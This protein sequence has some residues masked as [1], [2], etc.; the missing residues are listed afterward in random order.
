MPKATKA[1]GSGSSGNNVLCDVED[2]VGPV[3]WREVYANIMEMRSDKTAAVDSM[4]CQNA[5][6]AAEPEPVSTRKK[7]KIELPSWGDIHQLS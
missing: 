7:F 2:V 5:Q 3:N 4:G 1:A 6:D